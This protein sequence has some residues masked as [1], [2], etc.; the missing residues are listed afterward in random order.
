[1]LQTN[2]DTYFQLSHHLETI[3][4]F[5]KGIYEFEPQSEYY[6]KWK[7]QEIE[8]WTKELISIKQ[9]LDAKIETL[10]I[11]VILMCINSNTKIELPE[12]F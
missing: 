5:L 1:M 11:D 2:L 12:N 9:K 10:P 8:Y 4:T 3:N 7:E 6:V